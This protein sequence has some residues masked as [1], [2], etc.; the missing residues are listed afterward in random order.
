MCHKPSFTKQY[1]LLVVFWDHTAYGLTHYD[2]I[3]AQSW[4]KKTSRL[5]IKDFE[6]ILKD[7]LWSGADLCLTLGMGQI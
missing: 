7:S 2:S 4:Y 3:F 5:F 6:S 1:V